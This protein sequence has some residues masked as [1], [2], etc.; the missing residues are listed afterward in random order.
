[1][2]TLAFDKGQQEL[3]RARL[4]GPYSVTNTELQARK[5][6]LVKVSAPQL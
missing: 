5:A 3:I 2:G 6:I 1:M 4:L